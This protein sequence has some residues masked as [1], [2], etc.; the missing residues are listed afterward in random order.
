MGAAPFSGRGALVAQAVAGGGTLA[1]RAFS[2]LSPEWRGAR[3]LL[4]VPMVEGNERL[5][6]IGYELP[7]G[8][9]EVG[10]DLLEPV[11]TLTAH[12]AE[13]VVTK[14]VY[15]D[16][17]ELHRRLEPMSI[18]SEPAWQLLPPP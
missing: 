8:E 15:G 1:G 14:G 2:P 4:W 12:A 16:F 5:G 3:R 6:V 17:F 18:A 11:R 7:G 13:L 9:E 10:D